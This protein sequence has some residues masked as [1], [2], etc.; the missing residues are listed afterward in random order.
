MSGSPLLKRVRSGRSL[1]A[2]WRVIEDNGRF[3][4]SE[5][6]RSEIETFRD[7]A[8]LKL[9]SL[10]DRL[11]RGAFRFPPARAVPILKGDKKDRGNFRPIVLATVEARIV[12]RSVLGVLTDIP[13]LHPFFRNPNSF[14]GIRKSEGQE[15][16]AVP[17]AIHE[18]LAA[19]TPTVSVSRRCWS[20]LRSHAWTRSP[21]A[22]T[23]SPHRPTTPFGER[24]RSSGPSTRSARPC[25]SA[26]S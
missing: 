9:R 23:A 26:T 13:E 19:M 3:S 2:A 15:L 5:T 14:G 12:Q 8:S 20:S 16:A 7:R 6:V 17:A 18:V 10:S 11:R 24:V 21:S 4:K 22:W 1:E 25:A